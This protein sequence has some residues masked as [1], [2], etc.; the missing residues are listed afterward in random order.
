MAKAYTITSD[1]F[2][3]NGRV[4]ESG[5][6]TFTELE[7]SLPLDSLNQ[8]GIV[9]HAVYFSG[10]EPGSIAAQ[11]SR[12]SRQLTTTSQTAIVGSN[13]A[14]LLAMQ[15]TYITGGAAEFSGPHVVDV[16]SSNEPFQVADNLGLVA[17]DNLFLAIQGQHQAGAKAANVRV[18]CS[19]IKLTASAYAALVTNELSS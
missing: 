15:Q 7:I 4:T 17:T 16:V 2:Y 8:E 10:D 19:R 3:V 6:N 12:I 11:Q 1:P 18:V 5:A 13:N 14:N 9:V